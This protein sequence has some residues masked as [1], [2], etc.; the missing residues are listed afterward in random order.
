MGRNG[1][2]KFYGH[3]IMEN[4]FLLWLDWQCNHKNKRKENSW[5]YK[6]N[7]DRIFIEIYNTVLLKVTQIFFYKISKYLTATQ[8]EIY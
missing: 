3:K 1:L 8:Y 5:E 6:Y 7:Q 4:A 2:K